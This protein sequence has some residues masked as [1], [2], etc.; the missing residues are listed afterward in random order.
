M[1]SKY[2]DTIDLLF[3]DVMMP[4]IGG[5]EV[6][7]RCRALRPDL[8]VLFASGYAAESFS[9]G[10]PCPEGCTILQKPYSLAALLE[11]VQLQL[12]RPT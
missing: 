4:D 7:R 3:L 10:T 6:A 9:A 12:H 1:F 11:A 2:G 5:F 8:R